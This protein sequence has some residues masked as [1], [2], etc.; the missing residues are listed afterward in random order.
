M[1]SWITK[2]RYKIY[3]VLSGRCNSFLIT[4][5]TLVLLIDTG[6]KSSYKRLIRNIGSLNLPSNLEKILV[7]THTHF[8]HCQSASLM[9]ELHGF[10]IWVANTEKDFVK[11]GYTPIPKGTNSLTKILVT[12]GK[13]FLKPIHSYTPFCA[14]FIIDKDFSFT[15]FGANIKII[16]TSGHSIGSVSVIVDDE[17]ALVGDALFGI[18]PNSTFPPFADDTSEMVKSWGKLL[19]TNCSLFMP[20]H[21]RPVNRELLHREFERYSNIKF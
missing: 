19:Q 9:S 16:L 2:N 12:I 6:K 13:F 7:L 11:Q 8:D 21:G 17:I 14:D 1:Q 20:A 5:D 4:S 15:D 10:K 18:F 3:R